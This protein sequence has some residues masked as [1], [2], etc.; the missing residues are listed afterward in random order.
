MP[1]MGYKRQKR[2]CSGRW[3]D[4]ELNQLVKV[5]L[6]PEER[7]ALMIGCRAMECSLS[8]Y[9]RMLIKFHIA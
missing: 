1:R 3:V 6:T 5:Y 4:V 8:E 2:D 7:H 9:V